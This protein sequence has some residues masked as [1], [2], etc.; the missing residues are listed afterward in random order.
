[1]RDSRRRTNLKQLMLAA[2]L[3]F[4]WPGFMVAGDWQ[5][6]QLTHDGPGKF[7]SMKIDKDGNV[8]VVYAVDDGG[9]YPVK[10]GFWDHNLKRWF[11]MTIASGGS[12]CSLTLDSQ[13]HPHISWVDWGTMPGAKL[14]YAH[15]TGTEWKIA[16]IPLAADIVA[17][18]TSIALD[19]QDRPNISFYEY[20]GPKGTDFRVRLRVVRL[21]GQLWDVETID[22][23]N[24]SGKFNA[25]AID[26]QGHRHLAY[27]NV[28]GE[29]AGLRYAYS[30]SDSWKP[31]VVEGL[32]QR[33]SYE[34]YSACPDRGPRR[35]S[36]CFVFSILKSIPDQVRSSRKDGRWNIETV[37]QVAAVGYPD[38]NAIVLDDAGQPYIS[39]FD[40][41]QGVLKLAHR[42]MQKWIVETVDSAGAGF[43]SS[44]QIDRG[45]LWIGYADEAGNGFKVARRPLKSSEL[46]NSSATEGHSTTAN[47]GK[48]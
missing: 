18:Y 45:V 25:L 28:N 1:M 35:Q 8:H 31:E 38:R 23:Q 16:P 6:E 19:A 17:Y 11:V 4:I 43:T 37:D 41:G 48:Q 26:S 22:G 13:Q 40:A 12:F 42:E 5:I 24:Q 9:H 29:T 7:S 3:L 15:W 39:Y 27:A 36:S 14:R 2:G 46:A 21:N 10:Y 32:P 34:G 33:Q 20:T 47:Q 30:D 44:L